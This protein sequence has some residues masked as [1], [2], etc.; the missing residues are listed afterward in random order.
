MVK[1]IRAGLLARMVA[2]ISALEIWIALIVFAV[3]TRSEGLTESIFLVLVGTLISSY[4]LGFLFPDGFWSN[5]MSEIGA[6]GMVASLVGLVAL[7]IV[8]VSMVHIVYGIGMVVFG[9]VLVY[10][11]HAYNKEEGR[12]WF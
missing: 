6:M 12:P 7:A 1:E 9:G 3:I 4:L 2:I 11:A 10:I 5:R 8:M